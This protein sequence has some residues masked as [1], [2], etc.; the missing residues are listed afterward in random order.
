MLA[1]VYSSTC[2]GRYPAHLQELNDSNASFWF[3]LR[4]W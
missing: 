2:F 4:L 1:F 3:Y